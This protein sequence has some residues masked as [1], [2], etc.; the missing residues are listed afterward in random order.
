[1]NFNTQ[2]FVGFLTVL[3]LGACDGKQ[4]STDSDSSYVYSVSPQTGASAPVYDFG[5]N[6]GYQGVASNTASSVA[7]ASRKLEQKT[8][9]AELETGLKKQG[10]AFKTESRFDTS[11]RTYGSGSRE[12]I[13]VTIAPLNQLL[14]GTDVTNETQEVALRE[15]FSATSA[16]RS[17]FGFNQAVR[18]EIEIELKGKLVLGILAK[19]IDAKLN[20]LTSILDKEIYRSY[21]APWDLQYLDKILKT[22]GFDGAS[23]VASLQSA[24]TA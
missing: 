7:I 1:M 24:S 2:F 20:Q 14:L 23:Y 16:F 3:T 6:G 11:S 15:F 18:E 5:N 22:N 10:Y 19:K 9:L 12:I 17:A 8:R 13:E 21:G 4:D